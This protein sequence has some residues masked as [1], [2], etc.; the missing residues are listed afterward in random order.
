[1]RKTDLAILGNVHC[2]AQFVW[3]QNGDLNIESE[4]ACGRVVLL[5]LLYFSNLESVSIH[6]V[7]SVSQHPFMSTSSGC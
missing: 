6:S 4:L 1:M 7:K 3:Y 2:V 5:P